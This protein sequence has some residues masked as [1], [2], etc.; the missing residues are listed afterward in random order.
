MFR[1][2]RPLRIFM[3]SLV[4]LASLPPSTMSAEEVVVEPTGVYA[5]IDTRLATDTIEALTAGNEKK[6]AEAIAAI[7]AN[8]AEYAPPVFY[9]LSQV[10]FEQGDEDRAAFWFYAGQLRARFDVNRCAEE[11]ARQAVAALNQQFGPAINQHTFKDIP[12]LEE[13]IPRVVEWD[14]ETARSYDHRWINLH[15]LGVFL[16]AAEPDEPVGPLSLPEDQW[17]AIAETTRSEYL[18]GFRQAM[19]EVKSRR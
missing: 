18:E 15:G 14:R 4:V 6:R 17:E 1:P 12:K 2:P 16:L 13:L 8:P 10:L 3:L 5:E 19:A 9:V 7:E 11:S